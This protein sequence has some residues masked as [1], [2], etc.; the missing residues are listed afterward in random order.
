MESFS[1]FSFYLDFSLSTSFIIYSFLS[2]VLSLL[3][4]FLLCSVLYFFLVFTFF[5]VGGMC[6]CVCVHACSPSHL[7]NFCIF[8]EMGFY[9][10]GQAGLELLTS[11][12]PPASA[13]QSA[14]ITG[15]NHGTQ[16]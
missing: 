6:V 13:S 16:S 5:V 10:V 11:G 7:A 8:I 4:L 12:Y 15:V 2:Y 3:R 9:Y 1:F 14:G